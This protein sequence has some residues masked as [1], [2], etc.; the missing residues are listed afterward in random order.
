[1]GGLKPPPSPSLCAVPA[2]ALWF[3]S[4]Q[5]LP[6]WMFTR[7]D[8]LNIR[9]IFIGIPVYKWLSFRFRVLCLCGFANCVI[10][11]YCFLY[12]EHWNGFAASQKFCKIWPFLEKTNKN[13]RAQAIWKNWDFCLCLNLHEAFGHIKICFPVFI[14]CHFYPTMQLIIVISIFLN[15]DWC[16]GCFIFH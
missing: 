9:G 16:I 7:L 4:L 5:V 1:M 12:T 15:Y 13:A 6:N 8:Y 2:C 3:R 11:L 14:L 10:M